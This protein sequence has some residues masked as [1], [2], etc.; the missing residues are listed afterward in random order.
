MAAFEERVG[1]LRQESEGR[2]QELELS[3]N[4]VAVGEHMPQWLARSGLDVSQLV[5]SRSPAALMGTPDQMCEQLLERRE[6]LGISY[7]TVSAELIETFAPVVEQL[8]G[9]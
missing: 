3:L 8:A 7:I 1:W 5:A 2:F 6:A 4:L 9:R